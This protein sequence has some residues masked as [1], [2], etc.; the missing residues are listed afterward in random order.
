MTTFT[1]HVHY[2]VDLDGHIERRVSEMP[3]LLK[4]A[5]LSVS[6]PED[7]SPKVTAR[8]LRLLANEIEALPCE[9][10]SD[11]QGKLA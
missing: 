3:A 7:A 10:I 4:L 6:T 9:P 8:L 11:N 5:P 1:R 2:R